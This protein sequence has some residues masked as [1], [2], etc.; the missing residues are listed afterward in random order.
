MKSGSA[1]D[2]SDLQEALI[3]LL[4]SNPDTYYSIHTIASK[5][6]CND[7]V[8]MEAIGQ[9][10]KW[11]YRFDTDSHNH[12]KFAS[13]PDAIFPLEILYGLKT[14][15]IGRNIVARTSVGS[16]N[17][18]A[19]DLA[20]KNA[21]EGTVVIAEKQVE[22]RGRL[23]RSW[24]SPPKKGLWLTLILRPE[25]PPAQAP[26]LSILMAL[27]LS[28]ILRNKFKLESGIKW[29]NDCQID[30][31]KVTGILTEL[32]AELDRVDY[33]LIGMGINV[34][35]ARSDFPTELHKM[36][37]SVRMEYG[38]DVDRIGLLRMLFEQI[39]KNY[40]VFKKKGLKPFL[41]KIKKHSVL[42][43]KRIKLLKGR[44]IIQATAVDF[45]SD[46]A[47]IAKRKSELLRVT[48]G[49]V[50]VVKADRD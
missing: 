14:E 49:E 25:V 8:A 22:G 41:P 15:Y 4:R 7:R 16:T 46:G 35:L 1:H 31:R 33:V 40:E 6:G 29:P 12:F 2:P 5:I 44:K 10:S 36:A 3:S 38:E 18:I 30:G 47:L 27:S 9:L 28:E 45:D 13:P 50:T 39:E 34:N 11:G 42:L 48:A 24:H 17:D 21:P 20:E 37:T 26:S 19:R 23:G 32:S 43:G